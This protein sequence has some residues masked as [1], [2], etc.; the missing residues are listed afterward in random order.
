MLSPME[1][2]YIIYRYLLESGHLHSAYM[3][4]CEA[5]IHTFDI[6]PNDVPVG[7]LISLIQKGIQLLDIEMHLDING[8]LHICEQEFELFKP[9]SCIRTI[10]LAER[11]AE[12]S[13]EPTACPEVDIPLQTPQIFSVV[14]EAEIEAKVEPSV[15]QN[16]LDLLEKAKDIQVLD[17][18]D[19]SFVTAVAKLVFQAHDG[20]SAI[21]PEIVSDNIALLPAADVAPPI[22][23]MR[24]EGSVIDDGVSIHCDY[25]T[26]D[27]VDRIVQTSLIDDTLIVASESCISVLTDEEPD[28]SSN[29]TVYDIEDSDVHQITCMAIYEAS[30]IVAAGFNDGTLMLFKLTGDSALNIVYK[31]QPFGFVYLTKLIFES[32]RGIHLCAMGN[33]PRVFLFDL[34]TMQSLCWESSNDCS[35]CT[36]TAFSY[37]PLFFSDVLHTSLSHESYE[38]EGQKQSS[39]LCSDCAFLSPSAIVFAST[40]GF[41]YFIEIM[42]QPYPCVVTRARYSLGDSIVTTLAPI[43]ELALVIAGC[44]NGRSLILPQNATN[45]LPRY[46]LDVAQGM[47]TVYSYN[48]ATGCFLFGFTSG[49]VC[50]LRREYLS[51]ISWR[52]NLQSPVLAIAPFGRFICASVA[53]GYIY[54]LSNNGVIVQ[55]S[56]MLLGPIMGLTLYHDQLVA[57]GCSNRVAMITLPVLDTPSLQDTN[58]QERKVIV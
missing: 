57:Y 52:I 55:R 45:D 20:E 3:F 38:I 13:L 29:V 8:R 33:A 30:K 24:A 26:L 32:S 5:G 9:H 14:A 11:E 23:D 4:A 47:S 48:E 41:L 46:S 56:L 6:S 36:P 10:S 53:N 49:E 54:F 19:Q 58:D 51:D 35:N 1:F 31:A 21:H 7:T 25:Y 17:A 50:C 40:D 18:V 2:N 44:A 16:P 34:G 27:H 39:N 28:N 22:L 43:P 12:H 37:E 15:V 42:D